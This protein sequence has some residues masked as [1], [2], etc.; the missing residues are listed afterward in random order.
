MKIKKRKRLIGVKQ[1]PYMF[2]LPCLVIFIVFM[3]YPIIDSLLL[4]FQEFTAGEYRFVG[5]QNYKVMFSDP[6]FYKALG[7]T[8][9]YL[10]VQVP[11]MIIMALLIAVVIEQKF[12]RGKGFFRISV[13]L[14]T[15]TALVAYS[16]VFKVLFNT[17]NGLINYV[18][19]LFGMEK[20]KWIYSAWPARLSIIIA[21]TW[22]WTGYNMIILL[23]GIQSIPESLMESA[24]LDGASF[25][26]KLWYITIPSIKP[27]ILFTTITSTIG[28]L[29]LFDE[30]YILTQ[31]G[32][33]NAT[34]TIGQYLYQNGFQYM[35]FGYAAAIGYV[36]VFI[37]A[38]LSI[39]QFKVTKED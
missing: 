26:E 10:I 5:L 16:L 21:I 31:G 20:V 2:I 12:I 17:D 4:S 3:I 22:R 25:L 15:I 9:L 23:A 38:I 13:F 28:T 18:L 27:I 11:L 6:I 8:F 32:P 24:D 33:D 39:V 19:G 1:A 37:I 35:K 29:Q 14:P 30:A 7:N 36:M 34:I